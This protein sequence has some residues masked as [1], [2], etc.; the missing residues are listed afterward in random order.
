M[1]GMPERDAY[2]GR[3]RLTTALCS[4]TASTV[5]FYI[6][7]DGYWIELTYK[8]ALTSLSYLGTQNYVL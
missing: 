3:L 7:V 1:S 2:F 8:S 5:N 4:A 6:M